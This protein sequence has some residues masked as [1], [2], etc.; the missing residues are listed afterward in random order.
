VS[1]PSNAD[2]LPVIV[3]GLLAPALT[4]RARIVGGRGIGSIGGPDVVVV[5]ETGAELSCRCGKPPGGM[6]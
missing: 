6:T 4:G 1:T 3:F 5:I 2:F